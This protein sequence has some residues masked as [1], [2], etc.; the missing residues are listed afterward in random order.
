MLNTY[1]KRILAV[2][3][4]F[5]IYFNSLYA[6]PLFDG[7]TANAW[8]IDSKTGRVVGYD[9]G[10][11]LEQ[12]IASDYPGIPLDNNK[13]ILINNLANSSVTMTAEQPSLSLSGI[14]HQAITIGDQPFRDLIIS[15][16]AGTYDHTLAIT[17]R[18][19]KDFFE[20]QSPILKWTVASNP[21]QEHNFNTHN[22]AVIQEGF[23]SHTFYLV[24]DGTYPVNVELVTETGVVLAYASSSYTIAAGEDQFHRDT[25]GDGLPDIVELDIGLNPLLHDWNS[26][27]NGNGWSEFDLWLRRYCLDPHT[28]EP[29]VGD[30][31]LNSAG[32]PLDSDLDNW[33]DFDEILRG[34]HPFDPEPANDTNISNQ[35]QALTIPSINFC[36]ENDVFYFNV[37]FRNDADEII[38]RI[39]ADGSPFVSPSETIAVNFDQN[40]ELTIQNGLPRQAPAVRTTGTTT[41]D[42]WLDGSISD[43]TIMA[44]APNEWRIYGSVSVGATPFQASDTVNSVLVRGN[45][46]F[47][48]GSALVSGKRSDC[49]LNEN[50]E[51]LSEISERYRL[52]FKDFPSVSRLYEV[53][54]QI[55]TG[56]LEIPVAANLISDQQSSG[57]AQS[58]YSD[59][60]VQSFTASANNIAGLDVWLAADE[61]GGFDD[62]ILN[63]WKGGLRNKLLLSQTLSKVQINPQVDLLIPFR[64][65]ALAL[66]SG[67][68]Y[69]L[70]FRKRNA[71]LLS[72]GIDSYHAGEVIEANG[73]SVSNESDL[74]FTLY[75]DTNFVNGIGGT[76]SGMKWRTAIAADINGKVLYDVKRSLTNQ[77][78]IDAGLTSNDIVSRL[79][80]NT[81]LSSLDA[82]TLPPMRLPASSSIVISADHHFETDYNDN[83]DL[84]LGYS[85]IYKGWL[86]RIND[87][88]PEL[89]FHEITSDSW[90]TPD[91]WRNAFI[92]KLLARLTII[93]TPQIGIDST[94]VINAVESV[95][96]EESHLQGLAKNQLFASQSSMSDKMFARKWERSLRR[97]NVP[98]Y[99]L[100]SVVTQLTTAFEPTQFLEEHGK[101]LR[102][103]FFAAKP[104]TISDDYI[105]RLFYQS[106]NSNCFLHAEFE[107]TL[108]ADLVQWKAF[109]DRCPDY[110]NEQN[111]NDYLE[112]D[113]LRRYQL[114]LSLLPGAITALSLDTT[115]L[116]PSSDSDE[117]TVANHIE[118]N[119]PV[120]RLTLPWLEDSDGDQISD[121]IDKC[122]NDALNLCSSTPALPLL[123]ADEE[124][125]VVKPSSGEKIVLV[126][127]RL[128][129]MYD[130]AV[131]VY[132]ETFISLLDT[133][134]PGVDFVDVNSQVTIAPGQLTAII[135]LT[136]F[137][138]SNLDSNKTFSLQLTDTT[139][140]ILNESHGVVSISLNDPAMSFTIGGSVSGLNGTV[141]LQN[142]GEDLLSI[143]ENGNFIFAT[144]GSEDQFYNVSVLTQPQ[145]QTCIIGNSSGIASGNVSNID[146][147][148]SFVSVML[149]SE[150]TNF[151][152]TANKTKTLTFTWDASAGATYY[153]LLK[154]LDGVSQYV[155]VD[156]NITDNS[157]EEII[158]VHLQDWDFA[159]YSL[160]ACNSG[161]C[162]DSDL[163]INTSQYMTA[164][165]G[166]F[167]ASNA[168]EGDRFGGSV[169]LSADGNTFAIAAGAESSNAQGI[170]NDQ[171]NN[172]SSESGAVYIFSNEING[173]TQQA[174]VKASNTDVSDLFG[175]SLDI[176]ADGS[177]LVVGAYKEQ[178]NT[179][180]INGDQSDNSANGSG[181]VY[182]FSRDNGIW[183]QQAYIKASNTDIDDNFGMSVSISADGNTLALGA[184]NEDSNS[185]GVNGDQLNNLNKDSGAVYVFVR[186]GVNWSQQAYLKASNSNSNHYFGGSVA[187]SEDGSTLAVGARSESSS[188]TGVNGNEADSSAAGSGAVYVFIRES[189]DWRQQAYIKAS[190]VD[191]FDQFG[192][193]VA[194]SGDGHTLAVGAFAEDSS[195]SAI[196]G[197]ESDNSAFGS[198]AAYVFVRSNH[199]W[200]QQAYI[201]PSNMDA[202][203]RFGMNLALSLDGNMLAVGSNGED[204][205]AVGINQDDTDNSL[206]L[207][208]AV[209]IFV[210]E[211]TDWTQ[212]AYV[213]ASNTESGNQFGISM[214]LSADGKTLA[215]GAYFE[216]SSAQNINGDQNNN[217]APKS[218]AVYVY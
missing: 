191:A 132:Y 78:V 2:L 206:D 88:N 100:D 22:S 157:F 66:E 116:L 182:V 34:T 163:T 158:S 84:L 73:S 208:G 192:F 27:L 59:T 94:L 164:V 89:I 112:A 135:E 18:V 42:R 194:I 99:S 4:C 216:G 12:Y 20:N 92:Q 80:L 122:P 121:G 115:L 26:D 54:Y 74:I 202:V 125:V 68:I 32:L 97:F 118:I 204:S 213:K 181:A 148:C 7:T 63:I 33:S 144:P 85:R 83:Y 70:E 150:P 159:Y 168:D 155:V 105:A 178:S 146:V 44:L 119:R 161:G 76:R 215:V 114:R 187:L 75:Q 179:K 41:Y 104:G 127:I 190:T 128:D 156:S 214:S 108:R 16:E 14:G 145:R 149:P 31:C 46:N 58:A 113:Q 173:W 183:S 200:S 21:E 23:Y 11:W 64:F 111:L 53:E 15:P 3:I 52:R 180:G 101:W 56:L 35:G 96:S 50:T 106:Y 91:Q 60:V 37:A 209:Y 143:S 17:I 130:K 79:L 77:A 95:L 47:S 82:N 90:S 174:Y 151:K 6:S 86:P 67:E 28:R 5:F 49:D 61:A 211:N 138:G 152:V 196:N 198:G 203:D 51:V 193:S 169:A 205:N 107:T 71:K 43:F 207:S 166:Y 102:Q 197:D 134:T 38:F 65:E 124:I 167:K 93:Y 55:D 45:G 171:N 48:L 81:A 136:I 177:T 212:K 184:S 72:T 195:S 218:G 133:A 69:F 137:A 153:K 117:D 24:A 131:T 199:L 57:V 210:R 217:D 162:T 110:Y 39:G 129:R 142:N 165:I 123:F 154:N 120:N 103:T 109:F 186:E 175:S 141:T 189:L 30:I 185:V 29:L 139:N 172:L 140:A 188:S 19:R 147:H 126:G 62:I 1:F 10:R 98:D 40:G 9:M 8:L 170:N 201:K 160:Q 176:S 87:V 13:A 36:T 25:D